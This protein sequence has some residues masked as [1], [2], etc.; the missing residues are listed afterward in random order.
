M[1]KFFIYK[2][3]SLTTDKYYIG[4]T[5]NIASRWALHLLKMPN[6][7]S[8]KIW[9]Y[10]ED[11]SDV[12][13]DVITETG[14]PHRANELEK[15]YILKGKEEGRCV[16]IRVPLGDESAD[17]RQKKNYKI[18]LD[19]NRPKWNEYMR[20]RNLKKKEEILAIEKENADL[21]NENNN[22]RLFIAENIISLV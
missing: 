13:L 10:S 21:K 4:Q 20:Q 6:C 19:N 9:E 17:E 22:L 14:F 18:W 15:F 16:N 3:S 8:H 11:D 2:I 12:F 1:T 7:S 5:T